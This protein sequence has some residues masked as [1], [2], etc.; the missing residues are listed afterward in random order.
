MKHKILAT[1]SI[2]ALMGV[3]FPVLAQTAKT[4][5]Q[6]NAETGTTNS[7][8]QDASTAYENV[9]AMFIGRKASDES[10]P[11][12]IDSRHTAS[13]IIGQTVYNEKRENVAKV[14]D[15]ILER[16][17]KA[18]MVVV[19]GG[20]FN[21]GKETAFDFGAITRVDKEGDVIMPITQNTIDNAAAF[22]YDRADRG[23]ATTRVIPDN[24][25]SASR[26]LKGRILNQAGESIA[27]VDNISFKNGTANQLVVG[28]DKTFGFGGKKAVLNYGDT[29]IIRNGDSL[30]FQLSEEQSTML[31]RHK[32]LN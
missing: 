17:G 23:N 2:I 30:D 4:Q 5:T 14:T 12:V 24:G 16:N 28:Y 27:D 10:T 11:V 15:I 18:A 26:L 31:M 19:S 7:I 13:G 1:V 21:M 32:N 3:S 22:S 6:I 20:A 8:S 29:K 25:Y 9:K